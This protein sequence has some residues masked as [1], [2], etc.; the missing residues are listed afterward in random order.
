MP[1]LA[2]FLSKRR[3]A[4][5]CG[6]L[7]VQSHGSVNRLFNALIKRSFE[8]LPYEVL[9]CTPKLSSKDPLERLVADLFSGVV[10]DLVAHLR[11]LVAELIQ[12]DNSGARRHGIICPEG[13]IQAL[14]QVFNPTPTEE[15]HT[16]YDGGGAQARRD[17]VA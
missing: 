2:A 15:T 16:G 7:N 8:G 17:G 1:D 13:L 12:W 6:I 10:E 9:V 4:V 5:Q 11:L 14:A 3:V